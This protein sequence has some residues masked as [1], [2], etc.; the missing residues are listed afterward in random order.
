VSSGVEIDSLSKGGGGAINEAEDRAFRHGL[1]EENSFPEAPAEA[2]HYKLTLGQAVSSGGTLK[3]LSPQSETREDIG[4]RG[5]LAEHTIARHKKQ[6]SM[7]SISSISKEHVAKKLA[8]A[9]EEEEAAIS[10]MVSKRMRCLALISHNNMKPAMQD[11]VKAHSAVLCRFRLTGTASTMK[12]L[13]S[14]LGED[15]EYGPTCASGPLGGDAQ[16]G[17]QM[18]LQDLGGCIFFTDPLTAHPHAEDIATL[19]RMCDINNVLHATN[20]TTAEALVPVLRA[21]AEEG[22]HQLVPSFFRTMTCPHQSLIRGSAPSSVE[23]AD[24]NERISFL[25]APAKKL[26]VFRILRIKQKSRLKPSL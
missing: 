5:D 15:I 9:E 1:F 17:T 23:V 10:K 20:P 8:K 2:S 24:L 19:L 22:D 16:V 4:E 21:V 26:S 6:L 11:F 18:V 13:R 25:S 7:K 14:V 3:N 12:M